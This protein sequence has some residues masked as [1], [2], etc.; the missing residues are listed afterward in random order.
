[1]LY[2]NGDHAQRSLS[3]ARLNVDQRDEAA[4]STHDVND[5][6][7]SIEERIVSRRLIL[8][9]IILTLVGCASMPDVTLPYFLPRTGVEV[10]VTQTGACTKDDVPVVV[11][12]VKFL[13][14]YS[15]DRENGLRHFEF[16][17][18]G[19]GLSKADAAGAF[20]PV[21]TDG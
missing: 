14:S 6:C 21:I 20:Y 11:T 15:A 19:W 5:Q 9:P 4:C 17:K 10:I 16:G 1:M 12:D 8:I 18:L 13:T 3:L 2:F 7:K